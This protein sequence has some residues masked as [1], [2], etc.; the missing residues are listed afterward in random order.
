MDISDVADFFSKE[1]I[2]DFSAWLA[3]SAAQD[4][5]Y[6]IHPQGGFLFK[7]D[8]GATQLLYLYTTTDQAFISEK[9]QALRE[10]PLDVNSAGHVFR[11]FLFIADFAE[12]PAGAFIEFL[13][14]ELNANI[15][16][17][18]LTELIVYDFRAGTYLRV[19]GGR[20]Q[21]KYLRKILERAS[22]AAHMSPE[23]RRAATEQKKN[24]YR[25]TLRD[26]RPS[27]EK[28][29]LLHPLIVILIINISV[30]A[31]DL[32]LEA[33]MG[34]KPIEFFGI[35]YNDA[36]LEGEWWRLITSIFLHADFS[37]LLGNMLMLCY[38]SSIL[39]NFYSDLAYWIVY[40]TSGLA[41]SLLTL[42]FMDG[43][44]RSLGASGAI[45][46]LGGV[47]IYRMFFGKSARAFRY[48]GSYFI[49]A[50]MVIYNLFYGLFAENVNNYA[51]FSGFLTGFFLA[52]L[53][54]KLRQ[55]KNSRSGR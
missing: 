32:I 50:F 25:E 26:I 33:R 54:E 14:K 51:H 24:A 15:R 40:M 12:A 39:N 53:F 35:Q 7:R 5:Y 4:A 44:T 45:M 55:R 13:E 3:A 36:V 49:I 30:F 8:M 16:V 34:Y 9:M 48:A 38:L 27:R 41:G 43:A 29:S 42:L 46:G 28:K 11:T 17:K 2:N 52:M 47:L 6:K 21:D 22:V 10:E 19:G 23:E 37:H 31:L 18:L 1:N 20:V